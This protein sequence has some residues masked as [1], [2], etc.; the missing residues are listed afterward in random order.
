MGISLG[1]PIYLEVMYNLQIIT[2][3]K[4]YAFICY[5][6]SYVFLRICIGK[7]GKK[8]IKNTDR[9]RL[10]TLNRRKLFKNQSSNKKYVGIRS[11]G[12]DNY[13]GLAEPLLD[14]LDDDELEVKKNEFI[15]SL[16]VVDFNQIEINTRDQHQNQN[17]FQERKIRLTASRFGEICKMRPHTSCKI[18]VHNILYKPPV[19]SKQMAYGHDMEHKARIKFEEIIKL[20]VQTCGLVIDPDIPYFAAS[21]GNLV[22]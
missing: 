9:I 4:F 6:I 1:I 20:G 17:W 2:K 8:F 21:P 7:I 11:G 5:I 12:P 3:Y 19:L 22:Y 16:R 15:Q 13:Y 18:K 14:T 10:N